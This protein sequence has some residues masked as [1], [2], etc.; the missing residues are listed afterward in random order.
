MCVLLIFRTA[1]KVLTKVN[2]DEEYS[3]FLSTLFEEMLFLRLV[4]DKL[5]LK[6]AL[7]DL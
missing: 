5:I 3:P 7:F 4:V 2:N 6:A 1:T